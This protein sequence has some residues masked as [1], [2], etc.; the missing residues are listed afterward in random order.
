[1]KSG[2]QF[3]FLA[4]KRYVVSVDTGVGVRRLLQILCTAKDGSIYV[5]FPYARLAP[6][7]VG[8]AQIPVAPNVPRSVK[9]GHKFPATVHVVKFAHHTS[10]RAH[11]SLD[12]KVNTTV[13]RAAVPLSQVNGHLFSM[14][15]QG[16]QSFE[17]SD[18]SAPVKKGRSEVILSL[19][20]S[21]LPAVKIV[22]NL[23]R[24]DRLPWGSLQCL[25]GGVG[26]AVRMPDGKVLPGMLL[27]TALAADNKKWYLLVI[28]ESIPLVNHQGPAFMV[29]LGGFDHAQVAF[30]HARPLEYLTFFYPHRGS[31]ED[32]VAQAGSIDRV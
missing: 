14:M 8:V 17:V 26:F 1:M 2:N 11:F 23:Y 16:F 32:A 4:A 21:R 12:G 25:A 18:P 30:D 13:F 31:M 20:D 5:A 22:A 28:A 9:V 7:V 19:S 6:G 3:N 27:Q 15:I 10:G 29:F 24:E